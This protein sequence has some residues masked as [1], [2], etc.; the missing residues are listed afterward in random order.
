MCLQM[1]KSALCYTSSRLESWLRKVVVLN[2]TVPCLHSLL[3]W[4]IPTKTWI[5]EHLIGFKYVLTCEKQLNNITC[6]GDFWKSWLRVD[7]LSIVSF[8][9]RQTFVLQ[10]AFSPFLGFIAQ[11]LI[12]CQRGYTVQRSVGVVGLQ[13]ILLKCFIW[14][15]NI[16]NCETLKGKIQESKQIQ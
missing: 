4:N 11:F 6:C 8:T 15:I 7:I 9:V 10:T 2:L 16:A 3:S 12:I 1:W 14:K 5:Q 13:E